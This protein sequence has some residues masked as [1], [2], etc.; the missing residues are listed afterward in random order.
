LSI[1]R[2][3]EIQSSG[4]RLEIEAF[5]EGASLRCVH[6]SNCAEGVVAIGNFAMRVVAK[7]CGF[8]SEGIRL[9]ITHR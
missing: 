2:R 7:F 8:T 4:N 5:N 1:R 3:F 9:R 6:S